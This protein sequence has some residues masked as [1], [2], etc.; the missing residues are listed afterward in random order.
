ME[1]NAS[2][3]SARRGG[4]PSQKGAP[5]AGAQELQPST[6]AGGGQLQAG[7]PGSAEGQLQSDPASAGSHSHQG[8]D[9]AGGQS[10]Q[11]AAVASG[12]SADKTSV[13]SPPSIYGLEVT[14]RQEGFRRAGRAWSTTPT[15]IG[16]S[17]IN[18]EQALQLK[19]EPMLSIRPVLLPVCEEP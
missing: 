14:S 9:S 15:V 2:A 13:V 12:A 18:E 1:K 4:K 19:N 17:E 5:T 11:A 10:Q 8:E 3:A 7:Q 6:T 16:F